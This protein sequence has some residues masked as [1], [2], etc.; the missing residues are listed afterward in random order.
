MKKLIL[1]FL[2]I[3][4]AVMALAGS[5]W[6]GYVSNTDSPYDEIGITLNNAAP[7]PINRWGCAM[8]E[9][10]FA[11]SVPPYGCAGENATRWK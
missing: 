5:R 6:Y 2:T 11:K 8:L 10:R 4:V 9:T 1:V 3:I 7:D